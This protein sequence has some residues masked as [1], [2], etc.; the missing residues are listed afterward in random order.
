MLKFR[1]NLLM[2]RRRFKSIREY[3]V[4][5][6][7]VDLVLCAFTWSHTAEGHSYWSKL[8]VKW[9]S[10]CERFSIK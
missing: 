2:D 8:A 3:V 10:I 6:Q 4:D 1:R 9:Q 5:I 7:A